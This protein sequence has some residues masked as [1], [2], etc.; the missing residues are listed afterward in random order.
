MSVNP[1][2]PFY[3]NPGFVFAFYQYSHSPKTSM[4]EKIVSIATVSDC[5][6]VGIIP[7]N[8]SFFFEDGQTIK[9]LEVQDKVYT[10]FIGYGVQVQKISSVFN[11]AYEY[12]FVPVKIGEYV[13]GLKFLEGLNGSGYNY[14]SLPLTI[15]PSF[16]KY[17]SNDK[18]TSKTE[19][20]RVFCSQMALML[21]YE[22]DLCT[23]H[24]I[25]PSLCSPGDL[26]CII[27]NSSISFPCA[28]NV[29]EVVYN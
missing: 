7:V 19:H 26:R 21:L 23:E 15:L 10:S 18:K 20:Q 29:F 22:C 4:L 13:K 25:N 8:R 17:F 16:F 2:S 1:K 14:T 24:K 11:Q 3:Q 9:Q 12:T 5:V 6:H 28:I 27:D